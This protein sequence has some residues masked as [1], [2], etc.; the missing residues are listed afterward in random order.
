[1]WL[2]RSKD[3]NP[4]PDAQ[5][6]VAPP[7]PAAA[8][9]VIRVRLPDGLL[10]E[11]HVCS[12]AQSVGSLKAEL[13]R[14]YLSGPAPLPV[15]GSGLRLFVFQ[16]DKELGDSAVLTA[17]V[18]CCLLVA[19]CQPDKGGRGEDVVV[20]L[21][22]DGAE[23]VYNVSVCC[24]PREWSLWPAAGGS[25]IDGAEV[26]PKLP[27]P[28]V[29]GMT[30]GGKF[31]RRSA[32]AGGELRLLQ[33]P[34]EM[35][36]VCCWARSLNAAG[37]DTADTAPPRKYT[38]SILSAFKETVV[39]HLP[40]ILGAKGNVFSA[41]EGTTVFDCK[42]LLFNMLPPEMASGVSIFDFHLYRA[43]RLAAELTDDRA[44]LASVSGG[45]ELHLVI[46]F[47]KVDKL[48]NPEDP[49]WTDSMLLS[50]SALA[51]AATWA[52]WE[53]Y[54]D[55]GSIRTKVAVALVVIPL[56]AI[57]LL[58]RKKEP[59]AAQKEDEREDVVV[60]LPADPA[61]S[62]SF[63]VYSVKVGCPATL[64]GSDFTAWSVTPSDQEKLR[65]LP[66]PVSGEKSKFIAKERG[67]LLVDRVPSSMLEVW[68]RQ[69]RITGHEATEDTD[70]RAIEYKIVKK[71]SIQR[72]APV[73]PPSILLPS[74]PGAKL[75]ASQLVDTIVDDYVAPRLPIPHGS[76]RDR[77]LSELREKL[78]VAIANRRN[79]PNL[80]L[81]MGGMLLTVVPPP[82][83][84]AV[85]FIAP[86]LA[87]RVE[88]LLAQIDAQIADDDAVAP[89]TP[90]PWVF[91]M[92]IRPIISPR[93][94][95]DWGR[96]MVFSISRG[97][98]GLVLSTSTFS[99]LV[100]TATR[101]ASPGHS[102]SCA[103]DMEPQESV[104]TGAYSVLPIAT[105]FASV[106]GLAALASLFTY[107]GLYVLLDYVKDISTKSPITPLVLVLGPLAG[108]A[109]GL[110]LGAITELGS[111]L[112]ELSAT[113]FVVLL[114]FTL[115][116]SAYKAVLAAT[117]GAG[118]PTPA[119]AV[120]AGGGAGD[121]RM[122]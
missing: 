66:P 27:M 117:A 34:R 102:A 120:V 82:F 116:Y 32:G 73:K 13:Q 23:L 44:T 107:H 64:Y 92:L 4:V 118:P 29:W 85:P 1:M 86:I 6:L 61:D 47:C 53:A 31:V 105:P 37:T 87:E 17:P 33:V 81:A 28:R 84:L 83:E 3:D 43:D 101:L 77:V 18:E 65:R 35:T 46:A 111:P 114:G 16:G 26:Q 106:F 48:Q 19:Y 59:S 94:D 7:A 51:L 79:I 103:L 122:L 96:R 49:Y 109:L 91:E 78:K 54:S 108:A 113:T 30:F 14:Q 74:A 11:E 45:K 50:Y 68:V 38:L 76:I 71:S 88:S 12:E 99:L 75:T 39:V 15:P 67:A 100:A 2:L 80:K 119:A 90:G 72:V 104:I 8:S 110:A 20:R 121:S 9:A 98:F 55:Y 21:P 112:A 10:A 56:F 57:L 40:A 95:L 42:N 24:G 41:R 63:I 22:A 97:I 58:S 62:N 36:Q 5:L 25:G 93:L 115:V 89:S 52:A 70:A 60:Y 69:R